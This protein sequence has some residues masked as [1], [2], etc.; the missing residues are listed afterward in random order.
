MAA[1]AEDIEGGDYVG[2]SRFRGNRGHPKKM[3][4]S[5][6]SHDLEVAQQL[7]ETSEQLTG[8]EYQF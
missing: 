3:N 7:W 6:R 4:S 2:P 8:V 1:V 5:K